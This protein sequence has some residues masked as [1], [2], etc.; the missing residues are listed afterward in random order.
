MAFIRTQTKGP[1][2]RRAQGDPDIRQA[3]FQAFHPVLLIYEELHLYYG[4]GGQAS[5]VFSNS[6][7]ACHSPGWIVDTAPRPDQVG[8]TFFRLATKKSG[9]CYLRSPV[10]PRVRRTATRASSHICSVAM[11]ISRSN[12]LRVLQ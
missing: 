10:L 5:A 6:T 7:A 12:R 9:P 3:T 1:I 8:I 11:R 2:H 4:S